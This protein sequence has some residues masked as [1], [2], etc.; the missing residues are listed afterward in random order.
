[1]LAVALLGLALIGVFD[2]GLDRRLES[3]FLDT[4]TRRE[5]ELQ[6]S[7]LAAIQ[8]DDEDI[9]TAVSESLVDGYRV[10]LW[11][12]VGLALASSLSA[13]LLISREDKTA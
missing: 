12:A 6:R 13:A 3:L 7:G 9:R 11:I 2:R 5:I 8:T 4:G 10:V 1:L